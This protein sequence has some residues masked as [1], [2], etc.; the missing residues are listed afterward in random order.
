MGSISLFENMCKKT[1]HMEALYETFGTLGV[2][3]N[4]IH[5]IF[6]NQS[7]FKEIYISLLVITV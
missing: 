7:R 4:F 6:Y 5:Q 1:K 2:F 3:Y